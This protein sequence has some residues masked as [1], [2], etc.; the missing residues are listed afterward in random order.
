[1]DCVWA[2]AAGASATPAVIM[3]ATAHSNLVAKRRARLWARRP[4][5]R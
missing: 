1:M 3:A 2:P 5:R 4:V